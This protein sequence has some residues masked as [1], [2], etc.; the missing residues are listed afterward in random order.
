MGFFINTNR[1]KWK[2]LLEFVKLNIPGT[3]GVFIDS[4]FKEGLMLSAYDCNGRKNLIL[5]YNE[6]YK[7]CLGDDWNKEVKLC[8]FADDDERTVYLIKPVHIGERL[9]ECI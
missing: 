1:D 7:E 3:V 9:L 6:T 4:V 5:I 8:V 2:R